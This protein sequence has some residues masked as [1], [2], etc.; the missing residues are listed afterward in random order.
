M[1]KNTIEMAI[2]MGMETFEIAHHEYEGKRY[3]QTKETIFNFIEGFEKAI[4]TTCYFGTAYGD[5]EN[6]YDEPKHCI[7]EYRLPTEKL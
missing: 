6:G 7:I 5:A 1:L 2:A 3:T 4:P